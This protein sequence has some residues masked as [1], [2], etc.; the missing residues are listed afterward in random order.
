M[1]EAVDSNTT[2]APYSQAARS[3]TSRI[4]DKFAD[5]RDMLE[6]FNVMACEAA[7]DEPV[8]KGNF[9]N[10]MNLLHKL[11]MEELWEL[12][13]QVVATVEQ[14]SAGRELANH[15]DTD[16]WGHITRM[17]NEAY[18]E[19][20][21]SAAD[22]AEWSEADSIEF[23]RRVTR[24]YNELVARLDGSRHLLD[25]GSMLPWLELKLRRELG[26]ST[27]FAHPLL[28]DDIYADPS[29]LRAAFIVEKVKEG[30]SLAHISQALNIKKANIERVIRQLQVDSPKRKAI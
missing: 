29:D 12:R 28:P 16:L 11:I 9:V 19:A 1:P 21:R 18:R 6:A 25:V 27:D 17:V 13:R 4:A 24:L 5:V 7:L 2:R 20:G 30:F 23:T 3:P 22:D 10:G 26:L 8:V 15:I 14:E